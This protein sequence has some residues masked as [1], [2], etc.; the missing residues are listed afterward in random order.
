MDVKGNSWGG[1]HHNTVLAYLI[2]GRDFN[3]LIHFNG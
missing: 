3:F 1:T 2:K